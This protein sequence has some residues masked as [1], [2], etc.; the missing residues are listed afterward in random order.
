MI[1]EPA[2]APTIAT[3]TSTVTPP[4]YV[5]GAITIVSPSW[6]ASSAACT[7]EKQPGSFATQRLAAS[8]E[9]AAMAAMQPQANVAQTAMVERFISRS[10]CVSKCGFD[11]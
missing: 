11:V 2:P 4:A 10:P 8:A 1:V 7:V 6:A 9:G 5:P 3:L